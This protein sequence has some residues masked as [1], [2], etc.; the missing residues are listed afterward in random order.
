MEGSLPLL[1]E[2]YSSI[3]DLTKLVDAMY[4]VGYSRS[5]VKAYMG[6]NLSKVMKKCIG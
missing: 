6:G 2:G 1:I 3:L 5:G 4:G